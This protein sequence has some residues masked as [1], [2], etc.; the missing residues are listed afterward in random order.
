MNNKKLNGYNI[1][2]N[3]PNDLKSIIKSFY[4][5]GDDFFETA[6]FVTIDD[7]VFGFGYNDS[8]VCGQRYNRLIKEPLI[9]TELCDKRVKEFFNGRDF[10]LCLT[11]D[12]K[13][14]SW[15]GN[16]HGQLGFGCVNIKRYYSP[17][18]I[19]SLVD[20]KIIQVCCGERHSLV[21]TEEGV[22]YGWGDN[23]FGQT[24]VGQQNDNFIVSPRKWNI[25]SK[26]IKIHCSKYQSFAITPKGRVY[27]CGWNDYCQLGSQF[28]KGENVTIPS[29]I[30]NMVN[31]ESIITSRYNT[32]YVTSIGDISFYGLHDDNLNEIIQNFPL[33]NFSLKESPSINIKCSSNY[34]F[35]CW[36]YG[37]IYGENSI[38]FELKF[39]EVKK[40]EQTFEEYF[41]G[42]KLTYKTV[43]V[44]H[45][46]TSID[47][48]LCKSITEKIKPRYLKYENIIDKFEIS[49]N[50]TENMKKIIKHFHVFTFGKNILFVTI[51]DKVFGMGYNKNGVL[52]LGHQRK[53]KEVEIIPE[54]CDK[55]VIKFF[56]GNDFVLSLTRDNQ[57][58]S[59]GK[60]DHGQL[61][62]GQS[63]EYRIFKPQLIEYYNS[64]TIKIK[65]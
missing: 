47:L 60:N 42:K 65:M 4:V 30:D 61:G 41:H 29:L 15:G 39:N 50:I 57:L 20:V 43:H 11:S 9:I 53:V 17:H 28:D 6:L 7:K 58:F 27:C 44:D 59:W 10:V 52:G 32:Y 48:N 22:V 55:S 31:V 62:I 35:N 54:L 2:N 3:I 63:N 12:N 46:D 1:F 14:F 49:D 13:L 37:L 33:C 36:P 40:I 34:W 26:V 56:N 19:Q 16:H 25:E 38:I 8:G 45:D 51:D 21:L 5:F 23:R 64:K 24:G 18:L